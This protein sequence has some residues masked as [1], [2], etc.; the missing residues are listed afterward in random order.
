MDT[1]E[2]M[3]TLCRE[4]QTTNDQENFYAPNMG[5]YDGSFHR[6]D[7][8][9]DAEP[10]LDETPNRLSGNRHPLTDTFTIQHLFKTEDHEQT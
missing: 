4:S 10:P 9:S 1:T 3:A 7:S 8:E 5:L 2:A 6:L